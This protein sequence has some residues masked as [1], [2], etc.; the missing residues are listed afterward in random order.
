V[1]GFT[2]FELLLTLTLIILLSLGAS[3]VYFSMTRHA[4]YNEGIRLFHALQFARS[5]AIKSNQRITVCASEDFQHCTERGTDW[6]K[7]YIIIA[8]DKTLLRVEKNAPH[9]HLKSKNNKPVRFHGDGHCSTPTTLT[10]FTA[11]ENN[12]NR[13]IKISLSGRIKI[14]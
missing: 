11:I 13:D 4:I 6:S 10:F 9:T 5:E 3:T 2:L 7:G 1:K 14:I 12:E 8:Q